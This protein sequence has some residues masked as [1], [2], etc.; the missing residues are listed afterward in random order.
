MPALA[1]GPVPQPR[2]LRAGPGL[3]AIAKRSQEAAM[4]QAGQGLA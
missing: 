1:N 4:R 3:R 2:T